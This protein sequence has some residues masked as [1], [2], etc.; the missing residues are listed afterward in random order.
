MHIITKDKFINVDDPEKLLLT[1]IPIIAQKIDSNENALKFKELLF[2][3][4]TRVPEL[5]TYS[6]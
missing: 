6:D 1:Y 4:L 2:E 5:K 3:F